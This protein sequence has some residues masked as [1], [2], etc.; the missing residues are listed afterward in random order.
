MVLFPFLG[1]VLDRGEVE[2]VSRG[3]YIHLL[4]ETQMFTLTC[5]YIRQLW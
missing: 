3:I 4:F 2:I 5:Q 1:M